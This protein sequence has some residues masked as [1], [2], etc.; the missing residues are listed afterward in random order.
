MS[1]LGGLTFIHVSDIHFVKNSG[2]PY[3]IDEELREAMLIDLN[4]FAKPTLGK[5]DGILIC[6]DI[7]FS[8]KKNEYDISK[9]FLDSIVHIFELQNQDIYCVAGNHD[10]DQSV[11]QKSYIIQVLHDN[12]RGVKDSLQLDE[13][14]RRIQKDEIL[15]IKEGVLYKA[16]EEYNK[17]SQP[18]SCNYTVDKPNWSTSLRL[19]DKYYL[20]IHGMNSVLTS[21]HLDHYDDNGRRY[22]GEMERHMSINRKQI[23]R[24]KENTINMTLCH[25]PI[26]CW[27]DPDLASYV[28]N[29]VMIQ[30][31]GH[32][33][34]QSIDSNE[35]RIRICSGAL[36]PERGN[37]WQPM[38]NWI[39]IWIENNQL[40]VRIYPRK[41]DDHKGRF[42]ADHASC[43]GDQDYLTQ[44]ILIDDNPEVV[45]DDA[46]KEEED[47]VRR[48]NA[49]TKE[50]VYLFSVL[51]DSKQKAVLKQFPSIQYGI[52]Q[53][54][55]ILVS[56]IEAQSIQNQF[57]QV[58]KEA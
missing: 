34:K 42:I 17:F 28:D 33:H 35:R 48:T 12:L 8:G 55:D 1:K 52:E 31:Y 26:E 19:D 21:N 57:L 23:P 46:Q 38:Y 24:L 4:Q 44:C 29:R 43:D 30:L 15:N 25:H 2:D 27:N 47:F 9:T 10:V 54:I 6:G 41:Y 13:K 39:N 40:I 51:S 32:K 58:L 5:I 45:M 7:A 11:I 16:I 20:K 14:L 50:I 3:D 53:D 49:T 18:M 56:Q 37:G 36:Q 22:D